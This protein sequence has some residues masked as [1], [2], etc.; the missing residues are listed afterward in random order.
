MDNHKSMFESSISTG[1]M[2]KLPEAKAPGGLETKHFLFMVHDTEGHA[3][4]CVE[5]HRELA[6]QTT[7]QLYR[8]ATPSWTTIIFEKKKM[9]LLENYL[10]LLTNCSEMSVFGSY[11]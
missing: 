10:L 5:R 8:V 6:N 11:W 1:A 4:K 3:M 7:E 9:D 2:E